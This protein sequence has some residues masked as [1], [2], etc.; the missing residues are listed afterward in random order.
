MLPQKTWLTFNIAVMYAEYVGPATVAFRR[1]FVV[2]DRLSLYVVR[3]ITVSQI[4][5]PRTKFL[6]RKIAPVFVTGLGKCG[7]RYTAFFAQ[8]AGI[9]IHFFL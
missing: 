2:L 1:V 6:S 8:H 7:Y 3:V 4:Q 9:Y 5:P